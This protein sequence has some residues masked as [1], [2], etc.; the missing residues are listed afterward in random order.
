MVQGVKSSEDLLHSRDLDFVS[1]ELLHLAGPGQLLLDLLGARQVVV[2]GGRLDGQTPLHHQPGVPL[3]LGGILVRVVAAP[4]VDHAHLATVYHQSLVLHRASSH[5]PPRTQPPYL[6]QISSATN[7]CQSL[8]DH[9]DLRTLSPDL[10]LVELLVADVV[11]DVLHQEEDDGL[12]PP[13]EPPGLHQGPGQ[14]LQGVVVRDLKG[15]RSETFRP[16]T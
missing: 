7:V 1:Q 16:P 12:W 14:A 4:H 8:P 3:G 11:G 15:E 9:E 10:E 13:V 6:G 5:R 2:D